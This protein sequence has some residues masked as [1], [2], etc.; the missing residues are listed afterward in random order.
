MM[1]Y[2]SEILGKINKTQRILA[3][4]ILALTIVLITLGSSIIKTLRPDDTALRNQIQIQ[5][6]TIETLRGEQKIQSKRLSELNLLLIQNQ[7]ECTDRVIKRELEI[8][9]E[10]DNLILLIS[11]N[12]TSK[13]TI[14]STTSN[15]QYPIVY[16]ENGNEIHVLRSQVEPIPIIENNSSDELYIKQLNK[17]KKK[18]QKN[19]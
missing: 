17:I 11:K 18:I 5:T 14:K 8:T 6:Q 9:K 2:F 12:K 1:K 15:V 13:Q 4:I 16:D 19:K 7:T 3:L 10:I